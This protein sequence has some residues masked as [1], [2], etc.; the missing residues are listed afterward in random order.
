MG[1]SDQSLSWAPF[2]KRLS[3]KPKLFPCFSSNRQITKIQMWELCFRE[4]V[5]RPRI[6][7]CVMT[8][9]IAWTIWRIRRIAWPI[10]IKLAI[11]FS[12]IPIL[13]LHK[14]KNV[15]NFEA[16]NFAQPSPWLMMIP[17]QMSQFFRSWTCQRLCPRLSTS[18]ANTPRGELCC[19]TSTC[20]E[21]I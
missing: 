19:W 10:C 13:G 8:W 2:N 7:C 11:L 14:V 15:Y 6:Q 5:V 20:K 21:N 17:I 18:L 3:T 9:H 12:I 4:Q 16:R 1:W